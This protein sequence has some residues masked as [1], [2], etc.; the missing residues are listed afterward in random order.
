MSLPGAPRVKCFRNINFSKPQETLPTCT[1]VVQMRK[2]GLTNE[3]FAQMNQTLIL[4]MRMCMFR[5]GE[6]Y[7]KRSIFKC[8]VDSVWQFNSCTYYSGQV[9]QLRWNR[10]SICEN[11]SA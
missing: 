5:G 8:L 11:E 2:L 6:P 1:Q 4:D 7:T 10:G 9:N 3:G